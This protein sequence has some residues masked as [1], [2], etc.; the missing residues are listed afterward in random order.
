[1]AGCVDVADDWNALMKYADDVLSKPDAR[2]IIAANIKKQQARFENMSKLA[3]SLWT[4]RE[5]MDAG[6]F[7]AWTMQSMGLAPDKRNA[8]TLSDIHFPTPFASF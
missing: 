8:T 4:T 7:S 5:W 6:Q 3:L 2:E 1:M